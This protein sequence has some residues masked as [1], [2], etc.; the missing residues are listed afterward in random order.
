[1]N[2][3]VLNIIT[4]VVT[5]VIIPLITLLGK[6]LIEWVNI[7]IDSEVGKRHVEGAINIVTSVVKDVS[8]TYVDALKK[9]GHFG[10]EAQ[11]IAFTRS[12]STAKTLISKETQKYI[13]T[14]YG[15][16]D[17]W[18]QIQIEAAVADSK[19]A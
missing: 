1:M 5:A 2:E 11:E 17:K 18:L 19:G 16:F 13:K 12:L 7:K 9:E 3:I 14:L 15:D 4:V 6:K 10:K 8:Q